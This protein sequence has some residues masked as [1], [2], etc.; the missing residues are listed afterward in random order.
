MKILK[1]ESELQKN[2]RILRYYIILYNFIY[3]F[4]LYNL[5][6]KFIRKYKI[7]SQNNISFVKKKLCCTNVI[8]IKYF[9]F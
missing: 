6:K 7:K 1:K 8:Q 4:Y 9:D 5:Y 3:I 2:S